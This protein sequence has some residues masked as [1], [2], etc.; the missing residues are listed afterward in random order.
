[1]ALFLR[2]LAFTALLPGFVAGV[3]PWLLRR[4][5]PAPGNL[6]AWRYAGWVLIALGAGI[7]LASVATFAI[8]GKG[9]GA[10]FFVGPFRW[11]IGQEPAKFVSAALYSRVRNPMY[12]GVITAVA[13]QAIAFASPVLAGYAAFLMIFFHLTVV[14]I[15]EPH[16][17]RRDGAAFEQYCRDVPRWIPRLGSMTRAA[18]VT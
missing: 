11:L 18:A 15:E 5:Y 9:T 13:G 16:L 6:G 2:A 1:M 10:S 4:S 12:L 17:R 8:S 14:V 3:A 7:L